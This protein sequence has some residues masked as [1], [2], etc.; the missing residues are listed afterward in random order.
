MFNKSRKV[1][2][3]TKYLVIFVRGHGNTT[4]TVPTSST[5]I[6]TTSYV[7][8]VCVRQT[9]FLFHGILPTYIHFIEKYMQSNNAVYQI[10]HDYWSA[11]IIFMDFES[12]LPH[13]GKINTFLENV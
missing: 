2:S 5:L 10:T 11:V 1:K 13:L 6:K 7:E 8:S 12:V 3:N 4:T 9:R